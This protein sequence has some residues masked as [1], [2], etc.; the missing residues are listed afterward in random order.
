[1]KKWT[2]SW[3]LVLSG[4]LFS[5]A[6]EGWEKAKR[7]STLYWIIVGAVLVAN[8][9]FVFI[10]RDSILSDLAYLSKIFMKSGNHLTLQNGAF[11]TI[12]PVTKKQV[13]LQGFYPISLKI[14]FAT[15]VVFFSMALWLGSYLITLFVRTLSP[16]WK[17]ISFFRVLWRS[18]SYAAV[19]LFT[20]IPY[21]IGGS[22][23]VG[24]ISKAFA[25]TQADMNM[26]FTV[27]LYL[28]TLYRF[29]GLGM[30]LW[31]Y[32]LQ[33]C[34]RRDAR[35]QGLAC[36][37][38][39]FP[40][41]LIVIVAGYVCMWLFTLLFYVLPVAKLAFPTICALL[42]LPWQWTVSYL[43]GN[44]IFEHQKRVGDQ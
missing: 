4:K 22:V 28:L 26:A 29:W 39:F 18:F 16:V 12:D 31:V 35:L 2:Y 43:Y 7:Y 8:V 24:V 17:N 14:L 32:L 6:R 11:Y 23:L 10:F 15:I 42:A 19:A 20:S 5:F 34:S 30:G 37:Y 40:A 41:I 38:N 3:N 25:F 33:D 44:L 21:L 36:Y 1:M 13:L 27:M 9:A